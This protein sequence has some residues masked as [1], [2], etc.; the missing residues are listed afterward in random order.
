MPPNTAK[1][2]APPPQESA[3]EPRAHRVRF[4]RT[5]PALV[6][7]LT[8]VAILL[9]PTLAAATFTVSQEQVVV[10]T[11]D[12]IGGVQA[13]DGLRETMREADVAPDPLTYPT[14]QNL[15][16]GVQIAGIFPTDVQS[17]DGVYVQYRESTVG[18][19]VVQSNPA[20]ADPTCA[21]ASCGNG[22]SSDNSY[23]S[24]PA[25]GDVAIYENFTFNV[26]A[27]SSITRVE[28]GY[29][30]F[31]ATGNDHLAITLSWDGGTSW[32][33]AFTTGGLPGADPNAYTFVTFTAC[34]GHSWTPSDFSGN[35]STRLT[36][37]AAGQVDP[38]DLDAN[39]VRVTY[40]PL[41]YEL[42]LQY[43][44]TGVAAGQ[45]YDLRV[46]GRISDENIS[47]QVLTPPSVWTTRLTLKDPADQVLTY[48][49]APSER[50]SG[51][52][53]VRFVDA[54]GPDIAPS[55]LWLDYVDIVTTV[56]AYQL[57]VVQVI[58]GIAGPGPTLEVRGNISA[59]G[60]NFDVFLSSFTSGSWDLKASSVFTSSEET[61]SVPIAP[62]E[63]SNGT[64]RIDF[65]DTNPA[66]IVASALTLDVVRVTTTDATPGSSNLLLVGG[67]VAGITAV[68]LLA[69]FIILRRRRAPAEPEAEAPPKPGRFPAF[70]GLLAKGPPPT[71]PEISIGDLRP[72]GAY[73]VDEQEPA[74]AL[75]ALERLTRMGRS[76]LL[77]TRRNPLD[78]QRGFKLRHTKTVWLGEAAN[79]AGDQVL[80]VSLKL[81]STE[82]EGFLGTN[83]VGAVVIDGIQDLVDSND[84]PSV[85]Q[86]IQSTVGI[87][88][89]GQ[90]ILLVSMSPGAFR[91]RELK[92]LAQE[93]EVV[94]IK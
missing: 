52:V 93:L 68:A 47:V 32:C 2:F 58:S 90:Q 28:V 38:I 75:R 11:T 91:G 76:A 57:D 7:V 6:V 17:S 74:A 34:T 33:P 85:L 30:A 24:S 56:Y 1:A 22:V 45:G 66:D 63:I 69:A 82:V 64:V 29:E 70:S 72:G 12:G 79:S 92:L 60:E 18:P 87:V 3:F 23:A 49:L 15:S 37:S 86:L 44:W 13:E 54:K 4:D 53:S 94:R 5:Y 9:P 42:A 21:W 8:L 14:M 10:G 55:D 84:L 25:D 26:P 41:A 61:H 73:L 51:N 62:E 31:D 59:G 89:A 88:S 20:R 39:V 48:A 78:V 83:P 65:R 81:V 36:H 16:K 67:G 77:V 43:D 80:A 71:S 19:V 27:A 50:I 40:Q 35:L 46:K